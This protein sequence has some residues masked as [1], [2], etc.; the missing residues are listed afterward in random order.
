MK[1]LVKSKSERGLW[2][3][4]IPMPHVGDYDVLIKVKQA[5][6]CGTDL[7]IYSWDDWAK[8][9][10]P[11]GTTIGHEFTGEIVEVGSKVTKYG[12]GRRVT[13]EGHITCGK[14]RQCRSNQ[15]HLCPETEVIGIHKNGAFA[16]YVAVPEE[17][18]FL[19]PDHISNVIGSVMDPFGNAVHTAFSAPLKDQDVLI[20]GAGPIGIMAVAV[21]KHAG[22]RNIAISDI[23]E[24]RLHLAE[25]MGATH[26]I[27]VDEISVS[28]AVKD[29]DITVGME[30][31]GVPSALNDLIS[32]VTN[33]GHISLLGLLPQNTVINWD[34]VIFKMLTIKGIYGREIF[35]TWHRMAEILGEG[36]PLEPII[37]HRFKFEEFEKGFDAMFSGDSGKVVLE[38]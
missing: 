25:K 29:L 5:S 6:I 7:H 20:T 15:R 18:V 32:N 14:C 2:L 21:A 36:L 4:E 30:M 37:T 13:A 35:S 19:L 8:R 17:N 38:L 16:E 22:A 11:V 26:A 9:T 33:G 10:V 27:N 31:S 3:E 24:Y 12:P 28:E 1:A 34:D 23:N